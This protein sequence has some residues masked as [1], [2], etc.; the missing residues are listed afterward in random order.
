MSSQSLTV[1]LTL[2]RQ[3]RGLDLGYM[4]SRGYFTGLDGL[5][6]SRFT[7]LETLGL[8][9]FDPVRASELGWGLFLPRSLRALYMNDLE[10]A[11]PMVSPQADPA[12][13]PTYPVYLRGSKKAATVAA[14][15]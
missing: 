10:S 3:L 15:C 4:L 2:L 9:A 14:S 13:D 5:D 12:R 7:R 6:V 1:S 11:G 8:S